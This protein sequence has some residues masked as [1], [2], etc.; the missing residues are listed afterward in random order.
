MVAWLEIIG[1]AVVLVVV[2]GLAG[3]FMAR[4]QTSANLAQF[5]DAGRLLRGIRRPA[6]WLAGGMRGEL[7]DE[8]LEPPNRGRD[9]P[10]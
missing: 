6:S 8:E 5:V 3:S 2:L 9:E 7:G 1:V 4:A 10:S